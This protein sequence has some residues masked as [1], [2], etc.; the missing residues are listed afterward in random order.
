MKSRIQNVKRHSA[1]SKAIRRL[2]RKKAPEW[3]ETRLANTEQAPHAIWPN[4]KSLINRDGPRAPTRFYGTLGL[5]FLPTDKANAIA[6]CLE[7]QLTPHDLCDGNHERWVDARV[8]AVFETASN[9]PPP[10]WNRRP[11]GLLNLISSL[12]LRKSCGID[13]ITN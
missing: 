11:Y 13:G 6:G 7:N 9:A 1:G 12:T 3:W 4:A 2:N 8:H 10:S 5:K